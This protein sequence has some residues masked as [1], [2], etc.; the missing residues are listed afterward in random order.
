[1]IKQKTIKLQ[2]GKRYEIHWIDVNHSSD[3]IGFDKVDERVKI[4]E[5]PMVNI[6]YFLKA[7]PNSFVFTTGID[8]EEK[9]YFDLIIFPKCVIIKTREIKVGKIKLIK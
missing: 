6:G 8:N 7:T 9:Q 2:I 1:M 3:W 5:A 4:A